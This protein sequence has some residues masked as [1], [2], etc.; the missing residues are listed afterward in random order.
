[1]FE[2]QLSDLTDAV[3]RF[4]DLLR[5]EDS[6][7]ADFQRLFSECPSILSRSLPLRL[8]PSEIVPLGRPGRSEP[9]FVA[10]PR[11]RSPLGEYGTIELKRPDSRILKQP[12][13]G[14]LMLSNDA[15]TALA[16]SQFYG[17]QMLQPH[18]YETSQTLILGNHRYMF[19]IMGLSAELSLKLGTQLY[20]DQIRGLL[21]DNCQLIPYDTL[22][23]IFQ[24][25]VPPRLVILV[26]DVPP[27]FEATES[28]LSAFED[29]A[30]Q[31][32]GSFYD[33]FIFPKLVVN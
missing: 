3:A 26:P 9:D 22:F 10:Y 29:D 18:A 15:R 7:E 12:R 27:T 13:K 4:D 30:P 28:T 8:A 25:T 20:T 24:S 23:R 2:P 21:P 5:S 19:I 6:K 1:M 14:V 16:Q 32:A 11:R 33:G 17:R 31:T